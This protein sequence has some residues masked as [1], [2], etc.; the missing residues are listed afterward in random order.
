[1]VP[2]HLEDTGGGAGSA[3]AARGTERAGV[4][5]RGHPQPCWHQEPVSWKTAAQYMLCSPV[6]NRPPTST[7]PWPRNWGPWN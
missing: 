1:M 6:P 5:W 2:R 7:S 4:N 3:L